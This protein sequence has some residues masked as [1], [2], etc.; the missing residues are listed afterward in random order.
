M[1]EVDIGTPRGQSVDIGTPHGH[2]G[3]WQVAG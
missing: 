3:T 2:S 1:I